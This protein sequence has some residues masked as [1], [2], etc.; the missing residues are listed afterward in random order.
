[1]GDGNAHKGNILRKNN[2]CPPAVS[3]LWDC[4]AVV[5]SLGRGSRTDEEN[6]TEE[7]DT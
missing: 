4:S 7:F 2:L 6:R 3:S 5:M 1:M